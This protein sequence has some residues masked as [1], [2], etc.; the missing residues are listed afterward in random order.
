MFAPMGCRA[1]AEH[2]G[3][4]DGNGIA[5][6]L[7]GV[8][9]GRRE[10]LNRNAAAK[11]ESVAAGFNVVPGRPVQRRKYV[12]WVLKDEQEFSRLRRWCGIGTR[13]RANYNI[14]KG[15]WLEGEGWHEGA[16]SLWKRRRGIVGTV[17]RSQGAGPQQSLGGEGRPG[18]LNS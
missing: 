4:K 18:K 10:T 14:S 2:R 6:A 5:P 11:V 8:L 1:N 17:C 13:T 3:S 7:E 15:R 16:V 9:A 12:H